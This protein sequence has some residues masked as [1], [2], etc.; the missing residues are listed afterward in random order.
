MVDREQL[1][2]A[3]LVEVCACQH[4]DLADSIDTE[5]D[6]TLRAIVDHTEECDVCGQ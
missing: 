2:A 5:D 3:A 1:E 6:E 4:Y